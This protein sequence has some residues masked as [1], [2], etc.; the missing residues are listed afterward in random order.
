MRYVNRANLAKVAVDLAKKTDSTS[1][2]N[3]CGDILICAVPCDIL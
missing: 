1:C 2:L 3:H